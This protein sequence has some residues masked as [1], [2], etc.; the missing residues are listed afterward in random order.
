MIALFTCKYTTIVCIVIII[1]IIILILT[2]NHLL[3][4]ITILAL[5]LTL[6][7]WAWT[8]GTLRTD[9]RDLREAKNTITHQTS[10]TYIYIYMYIL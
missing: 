6:R 8:C 5:R 3:L 1:I 10:N 7:P 2:L 9:L 4:L